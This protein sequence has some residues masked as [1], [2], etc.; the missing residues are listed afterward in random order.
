M[1]GW[2]NQLNELEFEQTLGDS[3]GQERPAICSPWGCKELDTA[4]TEQQHCM[5]TLHC[6]YLGICISYAGTI[7][8]L[9][10]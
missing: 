3:E 1:V 9:C 10:P 8:E 2:Y 5:C 4:V 6:S 7:I